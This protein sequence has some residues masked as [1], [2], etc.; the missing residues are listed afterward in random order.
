MDSNYIQSFIL[1][2]SYLDIKIDEKEVIYEASNKNKPNQIDNLVSLAKDYAFI[3]KKKKTAIKHIDENLLPAIA[4]DVNGNPFLILKKNNDKFLIFNILLMTSQIYQ[5]PELS[6]IYS[7]E[8]ILI[9]H[10]EPI[11]KNQKNL[12]FLGLFHW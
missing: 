11:L 4:I 5:E 6:T 2:A 9:N 12:I 10:I 1:I 7:G 3:A 8:L